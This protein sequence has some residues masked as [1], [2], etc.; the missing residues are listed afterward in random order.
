MKVVLFCGGLGLRLREVSDTV[1]KPMVPIGVRPVLWHVMR[2]F[3]HYG[4]REFVLCLGYRSEVIKEYFLR[5]NEAISNDFVLTEGGRSL[6]LLSRDIDDWRIT[7]ADTGQNAVIGQR[8]LAVR[9]HVETD[10]VFLANYGDTLTDAPLD[11]LIAD[12]RAR[13][14]V[15]AFLCIRPTYSFHL[16]NVAADGVVQGIEHVQDSNIWINGGYFILRREIFDYIRPGEDLVNEPFNRL[17]AENALIGYRYDGFWAPMDT[18][19]DK[20]ELEALYE[21]GKPPWA[22]WQNDPPR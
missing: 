6:E 18:L 7:F 22:V 1:P 20:Q 3:A 8:L 16:V 10:D 9:R 11:D 4:H 2:Y 14:K 5:Y 21:S 13:D 12:F 15:A 17:I 19:K